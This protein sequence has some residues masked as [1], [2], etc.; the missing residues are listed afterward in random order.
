MPAKKKIRRK[1]RHKGPTQKLREVQ[2]EYAA[3]KKAHG[4]LEESY[5][6]RLQEL[7]D[8]E[9]E[10]IHIRHSAADAEQLAADNARELALTER[11]LTLLFSV[12]CFSNSPA[13]LVQALE[14]TASETDNMDELRPFF[15]RAMA[16]GFRR[17]LEHGWEHEAERIRQE[18]RREDV[19][20]LLDVIGVAVP[21]P[22]DDT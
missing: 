16:A 5:A 19:R 22:E 11:A 17:S 12:V 21:L 20:S 9:G 10:K 15:Q 8:L 6:R 18:A 3:L 14:R 4:E 13:D 2:A 7:I 1:V